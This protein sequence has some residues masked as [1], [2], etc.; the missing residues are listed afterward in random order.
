MTASVAVARPGC[1][2]ASQR[3]HCPLS[4]LAR[5]GED[6][7]LVER[8]GHP[9][10]HSKT[11]VF[12]GPP[13]KETPSIYL[14]GRSPLAIL[15]REQDNTDSLIYCDWLSMVGLLAIFRAHRRSEQ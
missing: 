9:K 8:N 10:D 1:H 4:Q 7:G 5:P 3:G 13:T 12:G 6:S 14:P 2:G 11:I 15:Q